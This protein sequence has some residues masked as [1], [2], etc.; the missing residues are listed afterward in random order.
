MLCPCLQ[1]NLCEPCRSSRF[2]QLRG[3]A[4]NRGEDWAERVA[5]EVPHGKAWPP[6]DGR[7]ADIARGLASDL[8]RDPQLLELLAAE[9]ALWAAKRWASSSRAGTS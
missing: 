1:D 3:V 8:T 4:A 9:L 5:R 7:A 6:H 2:S